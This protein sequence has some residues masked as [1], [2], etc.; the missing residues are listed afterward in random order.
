[1]GHWRPSPT[2]QV[3]ALVHAG[4][5]AGM[6]LDPGTW[7]V[8]TGML[9]ANHALLTTAGLLPRSKLLG[10]TLTHL[11]ADAAARGEVVIS[12]D[13]GPDPKVT[14]QVLDQLDA[15][16]ARA[17]FFCIGQR[18]TAHP[19][20][21]RDIIARGHTIENHSEHHWKRFSTLGPGAMAR[22]ISAAQAS[23]A[24]LT[25]RRPRYFRAPAGLRNPFLDPVLARLDLQLASWTRRAY[26]TRNGD[27]ASVL[28]RLTR[29]LAGGDILLLHDGNAARTPTG[30]AVILEVLPALL[31][32]IRAAGLTPVCL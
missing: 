2:L 16:G 28:A 3:S 13:D 4:A 21:V 11:P 23:L 18:A 5:L 22:E 25:G 24:A 19:G 9:V 26:D 17:S 10:P 29:G 14:P 30:Q 20:L 32:R 6:L 27:P 15:A 1:M 7:P 12:I 31:A 8:A